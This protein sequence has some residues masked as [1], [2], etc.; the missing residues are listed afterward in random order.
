[1]TPFAFTFP[2]LQWRR[3]RARPENAHGASFPQTDVGH[4][5]AGLACPLQPSTSDPASRN[6]ALQHPAS[7]LLMQHPAA[8]QIRKRIQNTYVIELFVTHN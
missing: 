8:L 2:A 4:L 7:F 5:D 3:C 6:E 1:M